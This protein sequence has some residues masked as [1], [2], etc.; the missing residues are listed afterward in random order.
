MDRLRRPPRRQRRGKFGDG[1]SIPDDQRLTPAPDIPVRSTKTVKWQ[2]FAFFDR[3]DIEFGSAHQSE[4]AGNIPDIRRLETRDTQQ[5][6]SDEG[7]LNR[8]RAGLAG[9]P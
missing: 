5:T 8:R 6:R 4:A 1:W 3:P 2:P 7:A 9:I